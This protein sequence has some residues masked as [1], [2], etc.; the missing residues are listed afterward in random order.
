MS[1]ICLIK[2]WENIHSTNKQ[3]NPWNTIPIKKPIVI[4]LVKKL[5]TFYESRR[6]L[7]V[8]T[9][10]QNL[11]LSWAILIQLTLFYS[12]SLRSSSIFSSHQRPVSSVVPFLNIFQTKFYILRSVL[13]SHPP[14][15]SQGPLILSSICVTWPTHPILHMCHMAHSSSIRV[16]WPTH[17][18]YVSHG[19]LILHMC[20]MAHSSYPP[21]VSH[22][23]LILSSICAT[24]PTHLILHMCHMAHSSY[25]LYVSHGPL[26]L[27][28]CY[29]AHSSS[30]CVTW[31]THPLYVSHGPLIL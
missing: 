27:H 11:S 22:G 1:R 26:I 17:P 10:T 16:T 9:R 7:S 31:P 3:T 19:P 6:F 2:V 28:T 12:I 14:Y 18:P 20:H 29:M 15:V 5:P 13:Y 23:P 24:W 21:Y 8:L 30:I 4:Q 25:P